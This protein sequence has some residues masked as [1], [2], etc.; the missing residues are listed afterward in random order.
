LMDYPVIADVDNDGSAEIVLGHMGY[1]K[2]FSVYGQG[3]GFWAPA[4]PLWD[5]HAYSIANI[6]NDFSIPVGGKQGFELQNTWHAAI[7]PNLGLDT[8]RFDLQ[9]EIVDVCDLQCGAGSLYV[10]V[11]AINRTPDL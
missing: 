6:H 2:A 1:G 11:Q 10:A 8:S 3:D 7:D 5:Q 9:A 4:R